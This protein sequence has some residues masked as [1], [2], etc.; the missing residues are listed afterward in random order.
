MVKTATNQ[1]LTT[2]RKNKFNFFAGGT[3]VYK[4]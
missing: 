2:L 3:R 1:R 4:L